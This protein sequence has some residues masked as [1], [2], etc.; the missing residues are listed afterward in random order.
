MSRSRTPDES[1][2][3]RDGSLD[4]DRVRA[5]AAPALQRWRGTA[6]HRVQ[7]RLRGLF[8]ASVVVLAIRLVLDPGGLTGALIAIWSLLALPVAV[9]AGAVLVLLRDPANAPS[10]WWDRAPIATLGVLS[11]AGVSRA[12][13]KSAVGRVAYELLFDDDGSDDGY[14]FETEETTVDLSV[15]ARIRRYVWYAI[16]GSAG[17]IV[18]DQA[19][20]SSALP[21]VVEGLIGSDPGTT[22]WAGL[23]VGAVVLGAVLGVILAAAEIGR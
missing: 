13:R 20:R 2:F 1:L 3:G 10:V 5:A 15:V 4:P 9:I 12:R 14:T 7:R 8:G 18:L 16:V 22:A 17:L 21:A 23:G 6:L 11:V 19:T